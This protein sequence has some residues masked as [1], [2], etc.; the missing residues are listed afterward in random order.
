M[1]TEQEKEKLI[2]VL[3][4]TPQTVKVEL[5]GYG[6]EVVMGTVD[7][8]IYDYFV[9][10]EIDVEEHVCDWN[11]ELE[12]PEE[13][14]FA[15]D[16]QWYDNDNIA[17]EN[18][19]EMDSACIIR[20]SD[21][22]DA[23]IWEHSLDVEELKN[24]GIDIECFSTDYIDDQET[25]SVVFFGQNFEK[26]LFFGGE[27]LLRS[28]FDPKKLTIRYCDVE[29][30]KV[31]SSLEYDEEELISDDYSTTGKSSHYSLTLV[32]ENGEKTYTSPDLPPV[33]YPN[34]S[35]YSRWFKF[36]KQ[37]P[38]HLGT[39]ECSWKGSGWSSYGRLIWNG[40][41]FVDIEFKKEKPVSFDSLEWRGLNW[42]T[43][44]WK[45]QP[46]K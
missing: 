23:V 38:Q 9:E 18:G 33:Y 1:A 40:T 34:D 4:F 25:G 36:P 27:F 21:E 30:F 13:Y 29:G 10:N 22:N 7:R 43:S 8:K 31:C 6:G 41:E 17:H 5:S 24:T 28:P 26:G 11:N 35:E 44:D 46:K 2:E 16:G 19:V 20:I 14:C 12:V 3:K 37:K 42:D 45:N 15:S 32:S 39:Y